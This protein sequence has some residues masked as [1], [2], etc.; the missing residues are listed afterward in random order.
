ML[1][2]YIY[3]ST[4]LLITYRSDIRANCDVNLCSIVIL[5]PKYLA[6]MLRMVQRG[7]KK[8]SETGPKRCC[9]GQNCTSTRSGTISTVCLMLVNSGKQVDLKKDFLIEMSK[10]TTTLKSRV[11]VQVLSVQVQ[12]K[13]TLT[14]SRLETARLLF[15]AV[16]DQC[17]IIDYHSFNKIFVNQNKNK[18]FKNDY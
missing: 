7:N 4:T 18:K 14:W 3:R 17:L 1:H 5:Y 16:N 15:Q 2:T 6:K 9:S 10:P 8:C 13:Q 12:P 11:D